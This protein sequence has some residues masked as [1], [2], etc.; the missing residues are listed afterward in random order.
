MIKV[1]ALTEYGPQIFEIESNFHYVRDLVERCAQKLKK[2]NVR[3][4]YDKDCQREIGSDQRI[5][6]AG[7]NQIIFVKIIENEFE[8]SSQYGDVVCWFIRDGVELEQGV[9]LRSDFTFEEVLDDAISQNIIQSMPQQIKVTNHRQ[10]QILAT[11]MEMQMFKLIDPNTR[12]PQLTIHFTTDGKDP[13][14]ENTQFNQQFPQKFPVFQGPRKEFQPN[15]SRNQNFQQQ[16]PNQQQQS[17]Q[18]FQQFSNNTTFQPQPLNAT[19]MQNKGQIHNT[20]FQPQLNF[21]QQKPQNFN[22][23]MQQSQQILQSNI[24]GQSA[25]ISQMQNNKPFQMNQPNSNQ[26]PQQGQQPGFPPTFTPNTIQ[27][28]KS[29]NQSLQ[30]NQ[31][32]PFM[33]PPKNPNLGLPN[34]NNPLQQ[35]F[36]NNYQQQHLESEAIKSL[37]QMAQKTVDSTFILGNFVFTI[38]Q[39][40]GYVSYKHINNKITGYFIEPKGK[41]ISL[42]N[43]NNLKWQTRLGVQIA[44]N[45]NLGFVIKWKNNTYNSILMNFL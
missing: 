13:I 37:E 27:P 24:I 6:Q 14:V 45:D 15:I 28:E 2:Q 16:L 8:Q 20:S 23:N 1:Q 4:Y 30:K 19:A 39:Q 10:S 31:N 11:L 44:L 36:Q 38:D 43:E 34:Q 32:N 18:Q 42:K 33:P 9:Q 26:K 5:E 40:G 25:I 41:E 22:N 12:D 29:P 3:L 21:P 17:F 35:Q 7:I